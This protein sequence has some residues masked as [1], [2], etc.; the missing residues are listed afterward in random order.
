MRRGG[1]NSCEGKKK[2]KKKKKKDKKDKKDQKSKEEKKKDKNEEQ[3]KGRDDL[4]AEA[5]AMGSDTRREA[6]WSEGE[7]LEEGDKGEEETR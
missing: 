7:R 4:G 1:L 2:K 3:A 5:K 6:A